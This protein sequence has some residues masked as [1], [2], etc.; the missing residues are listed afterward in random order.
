M[1]ANL[2]KEITSIWQ[3]ESGLTEITK[4]CFVKVKANFMKSMEA[5]IK[6]IIPITTKAENAATSA[7][8]DANR[9]LAECD[10]VKQTAEETANTVKS[11]KEARNAKT[12][13]VN[14]AT[15]SVA[16][17]ELERVKNSVIIRSDTEFDTA[18]KKNLRDQINKEYK[19]ITK[20]N[21]AMVIAEMELTSL[22]SPEVG[23]HKDKFHYRLTMDKPNS[24]KALF[25]LLKKQGDSNFKGLQVRNEVPGFLF[26]ENDKAG[27]FSSKI[28][29]KT[30]KAAK[31]RISINA[32]NKS[33]EIQV[34]IKTQGEDKPN[35]MT[36][37]SSNDTGET[38]IP[39]F[40]CHEDDTNEMIER[41]MEKVHSCF[42][43]AL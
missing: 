19:I 18:F 2:L 39:N 25:S 16:K 42:P 23:K 43:G 3:D 22:K 12:N 36:V 30:D 5:F 37:A 4:P 20:K 15:D 26:K 13:K 34:A 40:M 38:G 8:N 14:W 27:L 1:Q 6:V 17:S 7:K 32:K 24:K 31:T 9:A 21:K 41:I 35:F 11:E 33:I 29:E 28:R 10:T